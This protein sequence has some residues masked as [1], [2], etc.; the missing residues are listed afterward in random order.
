VRVD[1]RRGVKPAVEAASTATVKEDVSTAQ[2]LALALVQWLKFPRERQERCQVT[3]QPH[4][5]GPGRSTSDAAF[6]ALTKEIAQRNERAQKEARKPR[7]AREQQ[8]ARR[9]READLR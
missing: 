4:Q 2:C 8:Q 9:R 3:N 6:S 7:A 5:P 1:A